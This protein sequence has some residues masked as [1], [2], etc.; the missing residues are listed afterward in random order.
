LRFA[1]V[2]SKMIW[3]REASSEISVRLVPPNRIPCMATELA[4]RCGALQKHTRLRWFVTWEKLADRSRPALFP[5]IYF[6]VWFP[7]PGLATRD[8]RSGR[9]FT[10]L[11]TLEDT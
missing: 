11:Y 6:P 8:T 10:S 3:Q 4:I 5:R 1:Y 2:I 7:T 9:S